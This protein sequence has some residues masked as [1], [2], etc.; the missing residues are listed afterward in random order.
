[1]R[2][3]IRQQG[4]TDRRLEVGRKRNW[5]TGVTETKDSDISPRSRLFKALV[6]DAVMATM[7]LEGMSGGRAPAAMVTIQEKARDK[8][9]PDAIVEGFAAMTFDLRVKMRI[10]EIKAEERKAEEA[11][12][13]VHVEPNI[14]WGNHAFR[15]DPFGL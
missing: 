8:A 5:R 2:E 12:R 9:K 14:N 13:L 10:E 11:A 7:A 4:M 3:N 15:K 6:G 1:M